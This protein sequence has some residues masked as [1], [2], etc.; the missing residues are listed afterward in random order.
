M[1]A[2]LRLGEFYS[3]GERSAA[4]YGRAME[5]FR[6]AAETGNVGAKVR[7]AEMKAR[8]RGVPRTSPPLRQISSNLRR[9]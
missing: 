4:D 3:D 6:K 2:L 5:F 8:G 7:V 9:G 1:S